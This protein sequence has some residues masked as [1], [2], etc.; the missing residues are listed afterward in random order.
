MNLFNAFRTSVID[1]VYKYHS[2]NSNRTFNIP[3]S[4]GCEPGLLPCSYSSFPWL[5]R[6]ALGD[7]SLALGTCGWEGS[8]MPPPLILAQGLSLG[9]RGM[10]GLHQGIS[11]LEE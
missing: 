11:V 8:S 4:A 7:M 3:F 9:K 10:Q 6:D 1:G 5:Q 2:S